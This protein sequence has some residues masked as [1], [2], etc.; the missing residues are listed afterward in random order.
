M[1]SDLERTGWK[2]FRACFKEFKWIL[3]ERFEEATKDLI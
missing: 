1:Y 3:S 2:T